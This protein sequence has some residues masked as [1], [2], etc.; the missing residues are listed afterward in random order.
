M[1]QIS[2]ASLTCLDKRYIKLV[3][4]NMPVQVLVTMHSATDFRLEWN[5]PSNP[6]PTTTSQLHST[7][8]S[9]LQFFSPLLTFML[10]AYGLPLAAAL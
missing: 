2:L 6:N 10:Q 4:E 7:V 3:V 5:T 8:R 9:I 1:A